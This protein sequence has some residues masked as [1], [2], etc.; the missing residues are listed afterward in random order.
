[1]EGARV[2]TRFRVIPASPF[3]AAAEYR[4]VIAPRW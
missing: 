4:L 1:M 2:I 3:L